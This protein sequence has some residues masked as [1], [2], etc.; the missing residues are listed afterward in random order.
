MVNKTF[1]MKYE[2]LKEA[3]SQARKLQNY[4]EQFKNGQDYQELEAIV[5]SEVGKTLLDN[6][7]LLQNALV[8][9]VVAL[10]ND[11]D[12]YLL[13]DRMELLLLLRLQ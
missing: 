13:I 12:R 5:R 3:C 9:V 8:S 6:E 10:R 4:V 11:P 7:K 1:N 2:E